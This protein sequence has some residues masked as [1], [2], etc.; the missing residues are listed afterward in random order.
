MENK[1]SVKDKLSESAFKLFDLHNIEFKYGEIK[2]FDKT[3]IDDGQAGFRFNAVTGEK[4]DEWPGDE[5]IIIGYDSTTGCGD[6]PYIVKAD[7]ENLPVYWLMT[8]GGDWSSPCLVCDSL[9]I[10]NK[11]INMLKGYSSYFVDE[12]ITEEIKKEIF[13]KIREIEEKEEISWYWDS[14][15][16]NAMPLD[17]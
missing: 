2:F 12:N 7:N 11:I 8:D 16:S 17:E 13:N 14:L 3:T 5:Y 10:F 9:K 1:N 15:L 6:D 4:I